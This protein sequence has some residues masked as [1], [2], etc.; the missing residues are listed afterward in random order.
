LIKLLLFVFVGGGLGSVVRYLI[1]V[2]VPSEGF[3]W[4]T[5]A[6]NVISSLILGMVMGYL[7]TQG[8]LSEKWRLFLAVGFCGGFSTFS[9][10]SYETLDLFLR[11]DFSSG[12]LNILGSVVVCL[13]CIYL[14]MKLIAL[15]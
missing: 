4:A 6:A 12:L 1:S 8:G 14:G 10:F 2:A 9:T 13:F 3:P 11:Q 5:M 15:L 7:I